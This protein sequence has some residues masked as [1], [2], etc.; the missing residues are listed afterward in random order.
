MTKSRDHLRSM[1]LTSSM[2]AADGIAEGFERAGFVQADPIRSPARAQDL[3]L[4]HRVAGYC[5][6]DLEEHY[7]GLSLEEGMLFAYGFMRRDVWHDLHAGSGRALTTE[8]KRVLDMVIERGVVCSSDL[9]TEI[10]GGRMRNAWGGISRESKLLLESLHR[11][12]RLRVVRR[13]KGLRFYEVAPAFGTPS[14][15]EALRRLVLLVVGIMAPISRRVVCATMA[16]RARQLVGRGAARRVVSDLL[17]EGALRSGDIDGIEYVWIDGTVLA[18]VNP[19][20]VRFLAPFDPVVRD[21][22]R[23]EHLFGWAYRFEAYVPKAKRVRGYYAMPMQFGRRMVGWVNISA[24]A[25][26]RLEVSPGFVDG[27]PRGAPFDLGFDA[28][29]ARFEEFMGC[30]P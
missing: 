9:D 25:D 4:R 17:D 29:V 18:E 23:F 14:P 27:R 30:A 6:G 2:F 26:G 21:R 1:A 13:E 10:G 15:E 8:E 20:C 7:E 5:A 12:G 24:G 28:E 22:E 11:A 19:A 16:G 3:I